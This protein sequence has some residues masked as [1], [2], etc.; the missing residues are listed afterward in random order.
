MNY[1]ST[2]STLTSF[3]T[4]TNTELIYKPFSPNI[5]I[6]TTRYIPPKYSTRDEP[7]LDNYDQYNDHTYI[8]NNDHILDIG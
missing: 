6:D 8:T 7:T 2:H 3:D 5:D 4:M 1:Y